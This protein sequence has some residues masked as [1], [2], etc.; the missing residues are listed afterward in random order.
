MFNNRL[1][2]H[3]N[4]MVKIQ[5]T[6]FILGTHTLVPWPPAEGRGGGCE[7]RRSSLPWKIKHIFL[8]YGWLFSYF[9]VWGPFCYVFLLMG[10]PFHHVR[11]FL[12]PFSPIWG[13]FFATFFYL[14]GA[15][16][17]C[18]GLSAPFLSM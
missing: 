4:T 5:L 12:L 9:S 7:N 6:Y 17:P 10:G 1:E 13:L 3:N 16:S 11:A 18:E 15:F 2:V 14:W 8:L